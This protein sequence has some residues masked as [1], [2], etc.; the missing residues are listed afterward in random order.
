MKRPNF[1]QLKYAFEDVDFL[2][3]I[4]LIRKILS[5]KYLKKIFHLSQ[6]EAEI[7]NE[8]LKIQD[9]IKKKNKMK[10]KEKEVF[11]GGKSCNSEKCSS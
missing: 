6:E 8:D 4:Y 9:L 3:E 11:Y 1:E 5:K 10:K 2:I 7:G